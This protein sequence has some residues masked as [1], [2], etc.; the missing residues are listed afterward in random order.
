MAIELLNRIEA[1]LGVPFPMGAILSGPSVRE[2]A[3]PVLRQILE[4]LPV[5]ERE[6]APP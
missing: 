5:E 4:A 2:L 3:P 1:A 6:S